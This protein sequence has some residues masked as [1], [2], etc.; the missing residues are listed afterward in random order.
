V[1][2][3]PIN[4][5]PLL[6]AAVLPAGEGSNEAPYGHLKWQRASQQ[7]SRLARVSGCRAFTP[8]SSMDL[9][10]VYDGLLANLGH[11]CIGPPWNAARLH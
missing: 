8:S 4:I 11:A 1:P 10:A 9:P 7:L 3:C 6:K 5:G 2:I